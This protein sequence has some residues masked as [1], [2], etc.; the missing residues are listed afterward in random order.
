[1]SPDDF[2]G[3]EETML[4]DI[5]A[6]PGIPVENGAERDAGRNT[7]VLPVNLTVVDAVGL[8]AELS[9]LL[10]TSGAVRIDGSPVEAIDGAGLQLLAAF[11]KEVAARNGTVH[12]V[13]V[14]GVLHR[15]AGK[16]G[17]Q[18]ALMLDGAG[19]SC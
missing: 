12:W 19:A 10:F 6:V 13:G 3:Q 1:M 11:V 5:P 17:I 8:H 9:A 2:A 15:S 16:M 4:G 18:H 7:L 14:S